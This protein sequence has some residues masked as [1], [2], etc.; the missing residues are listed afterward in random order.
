[1]E[2][3]SPPS[4]QE[5]G[6]PSSLAGSWIAQEGKNGEECARLRGVIYGEQEAFTELGKNRKERRLETDIPGFLH[7]YPKL[8]IRVEYS[9]C[10][11]P[12]IEGFRQRPICTDS[13][14]L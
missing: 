7:T 8:Q 11:M 13:P 12:L 10:A 14:Y 1:M 3:N 4:V 5:K 2:Q 9:C 6:S